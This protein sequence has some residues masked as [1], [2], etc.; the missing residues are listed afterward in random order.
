MNELITKGSRLAQEFRTPGSCRQKGNLQPLMDSFPQTTPVFTG[1]T[2]SEKAPFLVQAS[3]TW[4]AVTVAKAPN[5]IWF[6]LPYVLY[7]IKSLKPLGIKEQTLWP[8][9]PTRWRPFA[10]GG[11]EP[12]KRLYTWERQ[13][14]ILDLEHSRSQTTEREGRMGEKAPPL[15]PRD[16]SPAKDRPNQDTRTAPSATAQQASQHWVAKAIYC[17][18]RNSSVEREPFWGSGSKA[19]RIV[20]KLIWPCS[21]PP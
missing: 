9:G 3:G 2:E 19:E 10:D 18:E 13:E 12:D 17:W 7:W 5:P 15:R 11:R 21:A 8:L 14:N 6:L 4:A 20:R 16:T 1:E